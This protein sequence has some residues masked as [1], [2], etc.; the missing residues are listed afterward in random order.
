MDFSDL[1]AKVQWAIE[2][3]EEARKIA[4]NAQTFANT[5][6]KNSQMYCYASLLALEMARLMGL[7]WIV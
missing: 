3:D 6:L 5:H 1:E 2:H 4:Q 7:E